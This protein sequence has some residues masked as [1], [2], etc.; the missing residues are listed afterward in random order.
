MGFGERKARRKGGKYERS[1]K[2][3]VGKRKWK[4]GRKVMEGRKG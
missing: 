4:V 3:E 1:D 2:L